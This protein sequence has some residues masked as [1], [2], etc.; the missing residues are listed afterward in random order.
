[1][2]ASDLIAEI[3]ARHTSCVFGG[4]GGSVV[5]LV[6]SISKH[7]KLRFISGQN[8]QASSIAADAYF[9]TTGKLGVAVGTSGPGLLNLLQG[10]ACSYF[11]SIPSL[12][13]S[14]AP[15]LKQIRKNKNIRQI[16]F[17][18][19]EVVNLVKPITKYAVLIKNKNKIEIIRK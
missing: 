17:Q 2:K 10:M 11:D 6:D 15:V 18:E 14:G 13:I 9:R 16:G 19:M 8:E 5:H 12:Y 1:M 4:Q 7:K 3:L